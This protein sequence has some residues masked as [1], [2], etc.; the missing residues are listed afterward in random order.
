MIWK[1]L[2]VNF[3]DSGGPLMFP[4]VKN[5]K[6]YFYQIGVVSYGIGKTFLTH[7]QNIETK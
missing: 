1:G 4:V 7:N 3:S 6:G 2:F 5:G